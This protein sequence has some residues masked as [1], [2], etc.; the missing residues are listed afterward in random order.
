MMY[1][2]EHVKTGNFYMV[3]ISFPFPGSLL[4]YHGIAYSPETNRL[5]LE[6]AILL[7]MDK[8]Q[9]MEFDRYRA[10]GSHHQYLLTFPCWKDGFSIQSIKSLSEKD[11]EHAQ[12]DRLIEIAEISQNIAS[13]TARAEAE[14]AR[15]QS[16]TRDFISQLKEKVQQ[17]TEARGELSRYDFLL[18]VQDKINAVKTIKHYYRAAHYR[19]NQATPE[20][21]M[22][23][24]LYPWNE[25]PDQE[26]CV[27]LK[28]STVFTAE[29]A[30]EV[31]KD[32]I[33]QSVKYM[34]DDL[35]RD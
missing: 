23:V 12:R 30:E 26:C 8:N 24:V 31:G 15:F 17:A 18:A 6:N 1:Q 13:E 34:T 21:P 9:F 33:L 10:S 2:P 25:D 4:P 11:L 28:A 5:C 20:S 35:L 19:E 3:N 27:D 7:D 16:L 14:C 29:Y 32:L 22:S